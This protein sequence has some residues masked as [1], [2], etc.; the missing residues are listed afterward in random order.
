V[1]LLLHFPGWNPRHPLLQIKQGVKVNSITN[2]TCHKGLHNNCG[3]TSV[4]VAESTSTAAIQ[5]RGLIC[6]TPAFKQGTHLLALFIGAHL[7]T[8]SFLQYTPTGGGHCH[9]GP[10]WTI[11]YFIICVVATPG[12]SS[13]FTRPAPPGLSFI[14][15]TSWHHRACHSLLEPTPLGFF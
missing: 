4:L 1:S 13:V 7:G 2:A 10:D 14:L 9:T 12:L 5:S 11:H 8:R 3:I 6:T 15:L